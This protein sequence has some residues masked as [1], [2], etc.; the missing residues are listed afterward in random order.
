MR[1]ERSAGGVIF[2]V[3]TDDQVEILVIRDSHDNWAF[4]KGRI[5]KGETPIQAAR[6]EIAEE[7]GLTEL[8]L[9]RPLGSTEFWFVDRWEQP[10]QKVHKYIQHYLFSAAAD[11]DAVASQEERIQEIRWIPLVTLPDFVS[12]PTLEPIVRRV[13]AVL[14]AR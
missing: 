10:G 13:V 9:V 6:R 3:R 4:P 1:T 11:A 12:Y 5:E 7:V 14:D 8:I 2:K